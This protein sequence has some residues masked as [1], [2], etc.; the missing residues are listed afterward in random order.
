MNIAFL[1]QCLRP[2]RAPC[3]VA[4]VAA[5][6]VG[7]QSAQAGQA[8]MLDKEVA[9]QPAQAAWLD[10][11][12]AAVKTDNADDIW[13][14][15]HPVSRACL[16]EAQKKHHEKTV[17]SKRL[18]QPIDQ[19]KFTQLHELLAG[20][21]R[22]YFQARYGDDLSKNIMPPHAMR[23]H[24][25]YEYGACG[26]FSTIENFYLAA[27]TNGNWYE[28]T[29]CAAPVQKSDEEFSAQEALIETDQAAVTIF[30]A[31]LN[32]MPQRAELISYIKTQP[33]LHQAIQKIAD[34]F[35]VPFLK[36]ADGVHQLCHS[37]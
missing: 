26:S 24:Y 17:I 28:V 13:A 32:D 4:L 37:Q 19:V 29:P 9:L 23:L 25:D 12:K 34:D 22:S 21:I 36:A 5:L 16:D 10:F 31:R 8:I 14:L 7:T 30:E 3:F 35:Q 15:V 20:D 6:F 1:L 2:S 27:Y 33:S 18:A 11:Y